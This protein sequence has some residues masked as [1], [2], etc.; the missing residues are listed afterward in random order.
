[1]MHKSLEGRTLFLHEDGGISE[2]LIVSDTT[3]DEWFRFRV[4]EVRAVRR[5]PFVQ[6]KPGEEYD[7]SHKRNGAGW[8]GQWSLR[9]A[10]LGDTL[11]PHYD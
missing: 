6:Y 8:G 5:M 10:P 4:R 3:D 1:M 2:V 11:A 7:L 9:N